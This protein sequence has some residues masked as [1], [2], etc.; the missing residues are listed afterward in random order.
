MRALSWG[1]VGKL[2]V[3]ECGWWGLFGRLG[4]LDAQVTHRQA[5]EDR[6]VEV[7][8]AQQWGRR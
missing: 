4:F 5:I 8:W 7:V 2:L 6:V 3:V 1:P